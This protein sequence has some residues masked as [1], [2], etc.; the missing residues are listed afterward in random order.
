MKAAIDGRYPL[1]DIAVAHRYVGTGRKKGN[2]VITVDRGG[3]R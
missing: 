1:A 2:V 3:E